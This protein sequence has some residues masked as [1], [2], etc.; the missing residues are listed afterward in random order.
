MCGIVGYIGKRQDINLGL[1]SLK[2]LEYRGYDSAGMA[3]YDPEKKKIFCV[4]AVGKITNLEK[5]LSKLNLKGSP[6]IFHTRWATHGGV[7]E[8]NAHP[9][10][11]CQKNIFLVHNGIIENFQELKEKLIKKGHKFNSQTDTE[12]VAH[13]IEEFFRGDLEEAV[14]KALRLIKGAYAL[15]IISEKDPNKIVVARNSAPLLFSIGEDGFLVASDPAAIIEYTRKMIALDDGEIAILT[16]ENFII[17]DLKRNHLSKKPL[18]IEWTLESAQKGGYP[19]FMLKEICEQPESLRNSLRGRII[20]E[21]GIVKLGGLEMIQD[22]LKEIE[23]IKLI[24]CGSSYYAGLY[25]AYLMEEYA[26]LEA[27]AELASEFRYR[28][29]KIDSKTAYLFISQSGETADTLAA[30]KEVK[31]QKGLC[32][33]LVNVVSSSIAREVEAG[34]YNHIGPEIA[35][36]ST[37]SFTSQMAILILISLFF[38]K[39]KG[40]AS[41]EDKKIISELAKIPQLV[42]KFLEKKREVKKLA[43]KY[44]KYHNFFCL[45]RKY[46]YPL[47]LEGALKLKEI[48]YLHAEGY[49]GG[50]MKHGP[51]ALIDE[52]FVTVAL[53][54]QDSVYEKIVSNVMEIKA[55]KGK[56]IAITNEGNKKLEKIADDIFYLPSV[57]EIFNPFFEAIF[58]QLLAYYLGILKGYDVDKPRNLAK[59]VTVE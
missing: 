56:I 13:L 14:I 20:P 12:V 10:F 48:A 24:A 46:N 19:H 36:A 52:N 29:P 59:S 42:E 11:D 50:E 37:K 54:P 25:G 49:A 6:F 1:S 28:H 33:G 44:S 39:L 53:C 5:K 57:S 7:T 17:Q 30:L 45:G 55:R 9:H 26:H 58:F 51:I 18:E 31:R 38:R 27:S 8:K 16:P 21:K 15:A 35:V 34:V 4:K 2:K 43:K 32:L 47:A 23:K 3:V 41:Q 22:K 40:I